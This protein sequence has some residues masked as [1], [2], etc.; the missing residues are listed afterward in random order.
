MDQIM[1][2]D[3]YALLEINDEKKELKFALTIY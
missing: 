3:I 2:G 1:S